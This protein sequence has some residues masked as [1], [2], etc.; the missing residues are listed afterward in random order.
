MGAAA[1][2]GTLAVGPDS[3]AR[4]A[5]RN[6]RSGPPGGSLV[7]ACNTAQELAPT[8]VIGSR[9]VCMR[10]TVPVVVSCLM[11]NMILPLQLHRSAGCAW[12]A[13]KRALGG[14]A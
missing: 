11:R 5:R 9:S 7:P 8:L 3:V 6:L 2:P 4:T 14:D 13:E 10:L 12:Q 1:V